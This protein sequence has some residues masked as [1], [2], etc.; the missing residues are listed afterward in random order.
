MAKVDFWRL[1]R[2]IQ[3]RFIAS[4]QGASAPTPIAVRPLARDSRVLVYAGLAVVIA[5]VAVASL[6]VGFGDLHSPYAIAPLWFMAVY[7]GLFTL[8]ALFVFRAMRRATSAYA[9]PYRPGVYLFPIGVLDA[10]TPQIAVY[11]LSE[12]SDARVVGRALR[13]TAAGTSFDFPAASAEQ[14][15]Q[16]AQ[17]V[18]ELRERLASTGPESNARARSLVDPLVDNGFR[19]PFSPRESLPPR[20]T[21]WFGAW[22]IWPI[23]LGVLLG[24]A[25]FLVRNYWSEAHLYAAARAADTGDAYRAYLARGGRNPDVADL[26]LPRSELRDAVSRQSVAAIE[27]FIELHPSSRIGPEIDAALRH[28]L[29]AE[30]RAAQGA[31]TLAALKELGVRY[32]RYSFLAP[33][34]DR[35]IEA[36]VA[37]ALQQLKPALAANQ[38]KL[39]PFMERLLRY[40][41]KHGPEVLVRFQRKPTETLETAEKALRLSAYF[42]GPPSLPGQYFDATHA[43]P[44][45]AA[46]AAL[47]ISALNEHLPRDLLDAKAAPALEATDDPK[48]GVPTLLVTYHTEMSGAFLSR[49]P[50]MA[51]SGIGLIAKA[52]F[53]IPGDPEALSFKLTVWRAPDLKTVTDSSTPGGLYE[54]MAN[55]AF[56]R[57]TKK[58]LATIFVEG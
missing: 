48:P 4:T 51:L 58:L 18:L 11:E 17:A 30:L 10:R 13:V 29:S 19:N 47:L 2:S 57:F 22:P 31:G 27:R 38:S 41:A 25:A 33:E 21:S 53:E 24:G 55:E 20:R 49:K 6:R 39:L 5:C 43:T 1:E 40:T 3:E 28:A 54:D 37:A 56:R 7:A 14:A 42:S 34:L 44:R 46:A 52:A 8:A 16:A 26:L 9:V 15:A 35:A 36:R 50:R 45:E 12:A 23:V 32:Q